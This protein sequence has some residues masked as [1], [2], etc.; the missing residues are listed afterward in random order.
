MSPSSRIGE[1]LVG[2]VNLEET[3][4]IVERRIAIRSS[5]GIGMVNLGESPVGGL[6]LDGG[7]VVVDAED[8]VETGGRASGS[9]G[10]LDGGGHRR[11]E[12]LGGGHGR[13]W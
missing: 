7:G 1:G 12:E 8:V 5:E 13:K 3:A 4:S 10:D 9:G 2:I 6:D 11:C